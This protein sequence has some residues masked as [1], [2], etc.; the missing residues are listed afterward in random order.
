MKDET[1][2]RVAFKAALEEVAATPTSKGPP[3]S[4]ALARRLARGD[5]STLV[6]RLGES[7][8]LAFEAR[9]SGN[10]TATLPRYQAVLAKVQ[11]IREAIPRTEDYEAIEE[12]VGAVMAENRRWRTVQNSTPKRS[13]R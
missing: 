10:T 4:L 11:A 13:S 2:R 8:R 9:V 1:E 12:A 7:R 5:E 3:E 6:D